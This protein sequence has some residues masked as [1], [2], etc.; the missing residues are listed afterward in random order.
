MKIKQDFV[1]NSSSTSYVIIAPKEDRK[2]LEEIEER[3]NKSHSS[4]YNTEVN[5]YVIGNK[6]RDGYFCEFDD[7]DFYGDGY[8]YNGKVYKN[9]IEIIEDKLNIISFDIDYCDDS[10]LIDDIKFKLKN[11]KAEIYDEG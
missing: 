1:T 5:G 11:T 9:L 8:K 7:T 3:I 2:L 4:M 6:I 10:G